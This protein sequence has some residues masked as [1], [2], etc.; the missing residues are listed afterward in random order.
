[1]S[2]LPDDFE[3]E[4]GESRYMKLQMGINRIRILSKAIY[5]WEYWED[6]KPVRVKKKDEVPDKYFKTK[7][8]KSQAKF[9]MAFCVFNQEL[10]EVQILELKQKQ[11]MTDIHEY[12]K[13]PKWGDPIGYD[14]VIKKKKTGNDATDVE[15]TVMPEPKEPLQDGVYQYYKD[16]AIN[17]E[18][19]WSG[20][21][22][23][24]STAAP[25]EDVDFNELAEGLE[26][27]KH[28]VLQAEDVKDSTERAA[29]KSLDEQ[30]NKGNP[31]PF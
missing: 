29:Q 20:E 21:D 4:K 23:F 28:D 1:M 14:I 24:D 27:D 25:A 30:A 2:F 11:L 3:M 26:K 31:T 10:A 18:A 9:F 12:T 6:N 22:P 5:G 19:L 8:W 13:N 17:L 16:L 7:D 15:Y